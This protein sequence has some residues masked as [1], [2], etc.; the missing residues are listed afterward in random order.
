MDGP[1]IAKEQFRSGHE[2][3]DMNFAT[4]TLDFELIFNLNSLVSFHAS[5]LP[6]L[7]EFS[8]F[9]GLIASGRNSSARQRHN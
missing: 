4:R 9:L 7:I 3:R 1:I 8:C 6:C 5:Q 2:F